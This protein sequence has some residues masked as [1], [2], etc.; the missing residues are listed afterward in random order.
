[1]G[2]LACLEFAHTQGC[3][4]TSA[5]CTAAAAGGHLECLMY[6]VENGCKI[7]E[8]VKRAAV[9]NHQRECVDFLRNIVLV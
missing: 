6:A 1:M 8:L 2:N 5:A 9:L 3:V 7:D 4:W